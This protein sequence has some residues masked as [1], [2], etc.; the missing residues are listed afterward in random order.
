MNALDAAYHTVHEYVGGAAAL[1]ARLGIRSAAVLNSKVNPNT[2]THHLRL[3]EAIKLMVFT[4]D[5][6]LLQAINYELGFISIPIPSKCTDTEINVMNHVLDIG[7]RKG[8]LCATI[9]DI[10]EDGI[11]TRD[12]AKTFRALA[13]RICS[14]V[15]SLANQLDSL[16]NKKPTPTSIG[17]GYGPLRQQRI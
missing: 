12:E 4:N 2:S 17:V 10:F 11:V 3:D 13:S 6:R 7:H 5:Y 14:G 15:M 8:E 1:A 9:K 16:S